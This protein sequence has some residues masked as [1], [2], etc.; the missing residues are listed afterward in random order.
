MHYLLK[1]TNR[2]VVVAGNID[3]YTLQLLAARVQPEGY[4]LISCG[5]RQRGWL[6]SV[7]QCIPEDLRGQGKTLVLVQGK[8]LDFV[9]NSQIRD[10]TVLRGLQDAFTHILAE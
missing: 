3:P 9:N 1:K 2:R 5:E 4:C 7:L 8:T 6:D 10:V